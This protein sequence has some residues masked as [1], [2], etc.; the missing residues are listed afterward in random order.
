M[1]KADQLAKLKQKALN[2]NLPLAQAATQLVF[3]EGNPETPVM[4]VGEA[5]GYYE[6]QQGR[7]FVGQAGQLLNKLIV[8]IDLRREDVY[9]TNVVKHRPP[10]NRDPLPDEIEAYRSILE[11]EMIIIQP[12][13]IAT[14]SRFALNLFL[15][16][17]KISRDHGQ[18]QKVGDLIIFPLYHPAAA[19]RSSEV[20][21]QLKVDF[22]RLGELLKRVKLVREELKP[23]LKQE[24]LL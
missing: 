14:I 15:P 10:N 5:P 23:K 1:T 11:E 22:L 12:K 8:S 3:G 16:Q 6:D 7:P 17:A 18:A 13:V 9:I 4:F 19:L 2:S 21:R 20:E 24:R